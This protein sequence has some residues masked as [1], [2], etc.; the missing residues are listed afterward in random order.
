MKELYRFLLLT[1]AVATCCT[2]QSCNDDSDDGASTYV[3]TN[4]VTYDGSLDGQLNFSYTYTQENKSDTQVRLRATGQFNRDVAPGTRLLLY[5]RYAAGFSYPESGEIILSNAT[6]AYTAP[7]TTVAATPELSELT[8]IRV[9][10]LNRAGA[11]I[12]LWCQLPY[13]DK[14]T[15][16][17]TLDAASEGSSNPTLYISTS[18]SDGS[19][20]AMTGTAASFDVSSIWNNPATRTLTVKI[21]N[22]ANPRY[23][24]FTFKKTTE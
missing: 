21:N 14:R 1:L 4:I 8:P 2:L 18:A 6:L 16:S 9:D 12:D 11:Y 23:N 19:V 24:T 17:I 20:G 3:Y 15:F 13:S 22:S 5:Y 7:V 10:A